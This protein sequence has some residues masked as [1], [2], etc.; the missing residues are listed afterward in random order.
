MKKSTS[1]IEPSTTTG[2]D[3]TALD[4]E[5]VMLQQRVTQ[6]EQQCTTLQT[7][8]HTLQQ[9]FLNTKN[10][11][12]QASCC[13][14]NCCCSCFKYLL[15]SLL[16][17]FVFFKY[18]FHFEFFFF[19]TPGLF[20][21]QQQTPDYYKVLN[22][23]EHATMEEIRKAYRAAMMQWHPDR[24]AQCG[25]ECVTKTRQVNEAYK[26]LSNQETRE[27]Y[28]TFGTAPPETMMNKARTDR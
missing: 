23:N 27:Y 2:E 13:R 19:Q 21:Q 12:Y 22:I 11:K 24:N 1:S 15:L 5:I 25:E 14:T 3:A 20:Q 4:N 10:E 9:E 26:V 16:I 6:V 7:Q 18:F 8:F 17:L 28:D